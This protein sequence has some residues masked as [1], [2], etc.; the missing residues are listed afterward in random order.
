MLNTFRTRDVAGALLSSDST[1]QV[2]SSRELL[3]FRPLVATG[4]AGLVFIVG[5]GVGAEA[6]APLLRPIAEQ[7]YPVHVV[8]LP[9]RVA[10]LESHKLTAI[11]RARSV[12]EYDPAVPGWVVAG[13]SLGGALASRLAVNAPEGVKAIVLIG[14]SHPKRDDLAGSSISFIKVVGTKDGVA[15]P[16]MV[17]TNRH[18][19]PAATSWVIVEGGNHSQFGHYGHQLFDGTPAIE[20]ERQQELTRTALLEALERAFRVHEVP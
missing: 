10:P 2:D 20:R 3:V 15:T 4:K 17:E 7:G 1:V 9:Y 5:A 16:E 18:L 6:Y 11:R 14:T 19:L 12:I 13:H 8:R